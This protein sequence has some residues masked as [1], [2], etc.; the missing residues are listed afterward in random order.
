M[1]GLGSKEWHVVMAQEKTRGP[2]GGVN[3]N[4]MTIVSFKKQE[5][6]PFL[7]IEPCT[8]QPWIYKGCPE[9]HV[10]GKVETLMVGYF[11]DSPHIRWILCQ[12]FPLLRVSLLRI[13]QAQ[14]NR[15]G[16][17][18]VWG[19]GLSAPNLGSHRKITEMRLLLWTTDGSKVKR[20]MEIFPTSAIV[21]YLWP[22]TSTETS[23][24]I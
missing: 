1:V 14:I 6:H 23:F 21:K 16:A 12:V 22:L 2:H 20:K 15:F 3:N 4:S 7:S 8:H 5:M 24:W 10:I 18:P 19:P 11:S 9:S 17:F 13:P